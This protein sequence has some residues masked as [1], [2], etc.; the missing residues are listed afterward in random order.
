MII[1]RAS[2][3]FRRAVLGALVL[4]LPRSSP[5]PGRFPQSS[6][7]K[8]PYPIPYLQ[9]SCHLASNC[10]ILQ[11]T[12]RQPGTLDPYPSSQQ[13]PHVPPRPLLIQDPV[14]TLL[15]SYRISLLQ[16]HFGVAFAAEVLCGRSCDVGGGGVEVGTG[17]LE[18][19]RGVGFARH[20]GGR[21]AKVVF[22]LV[23]EYAIRLL[24]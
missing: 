6:T 16:L 7:I 10:T 1:R 2:C 3:H 14:P 12:A 11:S 24:W 20:C 22:W 17:G 18:A 5:T 19:W 8:Q 4:T 21:C 9:I 15:A 13:E 23:V